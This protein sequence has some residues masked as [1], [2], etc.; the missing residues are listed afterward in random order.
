MRAYLHVGRA[1]LVVSTI[2]LS[3][4]LHGRER[5]PLQTEGMRVR[6]ANTR[7]TPVDHVVV[8]YEQRLVTV[9]NIRLFQLTNSI[10]IARDC[11]AREGLQVFFVACGERPR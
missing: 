9:I 10:K 8:Q 7:M 11:I 6:R 4:G 2:S 5:K 1:V 3:S